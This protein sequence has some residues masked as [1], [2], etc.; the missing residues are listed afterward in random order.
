MASR[1]I[2]EIRHL[3]LVA[4]IANEGSVS[5][6]ARHLN[7]SQSAVSHQ[8]ISL[9]Q[10]LGCQLFERIGKRMA[11]TSAGVKI[12]TAAGPIMDALDDVERAILNPAA[13]Q[14]V[15]RVA[16]SCSTILGWLGKQA[17][18]LSTRFPYAN[19]KLSY[20]IGDQH[21]DALLN[22]RLDLVITN[23]PHDDARLRHRPL[24]S[25]ETV[26]VTSSDRSF[27]TTRSGRI[28]W[29]DLRHSTI[30]I[31]DLPREDQIALRRAIGASSSTRIM[32]IQL[33]EAIFQLVRD[34]HGIGLISRWPGDHVDISGLT[35]R[36]LSPPHS[37]EFY[38]SYRASADDEVLAGLI[39]Q[40]A[41]G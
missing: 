11:P 6:A 34:G 26:A 14:S 20:D 24:F 5:R 39:E 36:S 41:S 31:H 9:E 28:R 38:A 27:P 22:A 17:V 1:G 29:A 32:Q 10:A 23:R 35:I 15:I 18:R 8:L 13:G 3:R 12:A 16:A 25:L 30:L 40:M 2:F 21:A 37:R 4:S 19:V 33:T 7:L